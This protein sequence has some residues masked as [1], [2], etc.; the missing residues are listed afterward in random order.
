MDIV[1]RLIKIFQIFFKKKLGSL[2]K[3]QSP[4]FDHHGWQLNFFNCLVE[5]PKVV[6]MLRQILI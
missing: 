2:N 1:N 3:I 4:T 5:Q 6:N